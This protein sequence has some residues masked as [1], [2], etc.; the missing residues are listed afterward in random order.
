VSA[1]TRVLSCATITANTRKSLT[2]NARDT[3][4]VK[5]ALSASRAS[6]R[7]NSLDSAERIAV[8]KL[9]VV[10]RS[11]RATVNASKKEISLDV[12]AIQ[13]SLLTA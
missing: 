1:T 4:W 7:I 2:A 12:C 3:T 8:A 13:V 9:M 10:K 11:A 5:I 6:L